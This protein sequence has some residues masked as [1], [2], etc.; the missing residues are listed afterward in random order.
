M[1]KFIMSTIPDLVNL[2]KD[3]FI[4]QLF[5][6]LFCDILY[7]PPSVNYYHFSRFVPFAVDGEVLVL[8]AGL[9]IVLSSFILGVLIKRYFSDI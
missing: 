6:I 4:L 1:V 7:L 8:S 9:L 5:S 3:K 2:C